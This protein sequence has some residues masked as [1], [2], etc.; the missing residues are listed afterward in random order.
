M[1]NLPWA[2]T[3]I[4]D[5]SYQVAHAAFYKE[6]TVLEFMKD[7]NIISGDDLRNK[8]LNKLLSHNELKELQKSLKDLK[9]R[10]THSQIPRVYKIIDVMDK[11]ANNQVF[12]MDDKT[13]TVLEYFTK[14]YPRFRMQYPH[15]NVLRA[16]PSNKTIFLPIELI[17]SPRSS[18]TLLHSSSFSS[19]TSR[20]FL[21]CTMSSAKSIHHG[22]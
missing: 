7:H 9:V 8:T 18:I 20:L 16:S 10:V 12:K 19:T 22:D 3:L 17:F 11:G 15:L 2:N 21:L 5:R 14:M 6:Q 1:Y 13:V 4:L